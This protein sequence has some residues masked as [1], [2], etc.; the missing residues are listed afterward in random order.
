[1]KAVVRPGGHERTDRGWNASPASAIPAAE[2]IT[3]SIRPGAVRGDCALRHDG[4]GSALAL[5]PSAEQACDTHV[6]G[7]PW[8]RALA[9]AGH[10][11]LAP[12]TPGTLAA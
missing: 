5:I 10:V 9:R 4:T 3:G 1:M 2:A 11:R 6:P 8:G 12:G 7:T